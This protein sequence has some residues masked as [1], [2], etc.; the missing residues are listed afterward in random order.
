VDADRVFF[1]INSLFCFYVGVNLLGKAVSQWR[2]GWMQD[3]AQQD[4]DKYL[5][6]V[7]RH[8]AQQS[9]YFAVFAGYIPALMLISLM[10]SFYLYLHERSRSV[11]LIAFVFG[12]ALG[13]MWI[14]RR[15]FG[16]AISAMAAKYMNATSVAAKQDLFSQ[17]K[18]LYYYESLGN[19]V[20]GHTS[21]IA[22][23]LF[24]F[25]FLKGKG[26]E[27]SVGALFLSSSVAL[28]V[29]QFM[30]PSSW[31]IEAAGVMILP[32]LA[33]LL[34]SILLWKYKPSVEVWVE[35]PKPTAA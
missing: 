6:L 5:D 7:L 23:A 25:L 17:V 3:L 32:A 1:K 28:I 11:S 9:F 33:F 19:L 12:T 31:L 8:F 4:M 18:S 29:Y 22:Y 30:T 21:L 2:S 16:T 24:G 15:L 20:S 13:A 14:S 27:F 34:S 26:L 10:V 35:Q